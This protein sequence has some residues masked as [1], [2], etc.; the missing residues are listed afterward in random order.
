ME[1]KELIGAFAAEAG[2]KETPVADD[3]GGFTFEIDDITISFVETEG[4]HELV[5]SR[6]SANF[7]IRAKS[8]S[9]DT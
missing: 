4:S 2:I 9:S 8:R 7:P 5:R 1:L 3:A 6:W